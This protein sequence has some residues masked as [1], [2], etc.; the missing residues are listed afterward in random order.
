MPRSTQRQDLHNALDVDQ[1]IIPLVRTGTVT[2]S[3]VDAKDHARTAIVFEYGTITD[4]TFTPSL[5]ESD[6]QGSGYSAVDASDIEGTLTAGT[7]SADETA[8]VVSYTGTKRY[9]KAKLTASGS[10]S[11]GGTVAAHVVGFKDTAF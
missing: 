5:E 3:A 2:G 11:T 6:A 7:S 9:L 10:P 8:V 4:G 1:S